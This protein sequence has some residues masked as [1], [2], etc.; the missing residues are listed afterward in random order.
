MLILLLLSQHHDP[1]Q[2]LGV[3]RLKLQNFLESNIC[4]FRLI[5]LLVEDTQVKPDFTEIRL[6]SRSF[7][8]CVKRVLELLLQV[9]K[10]RE[11]GPEDSISRRLKL[12]CLET[13]V[14]LVKFLED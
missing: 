12:G 10:D 5:T 9:E 2:S 7:N 11:R 8:D 1:I 4:F 14:S 6:Q 3:A 13:V